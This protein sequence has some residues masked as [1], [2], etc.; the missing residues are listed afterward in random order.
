MNASNAK[1]I[2]SAFS[3][4]DQRHRGVVLV[5][6]L[7]AIVL[8]ASLLYYVL[9]LGKHVNNRIVAQHSAD[10]AANAAAAT[11]TACPPSDATLRWRRA[12][13]LRLR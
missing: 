12:S 10:A 11:R 8:I 4:H 7:L 5:I 13:Q 2:S 1:N 6:M 3:P 9:N